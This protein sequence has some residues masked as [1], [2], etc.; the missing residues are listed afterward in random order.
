MYDNDDPVQRANLIKV[1]AAYGLDAWEFN[2]GGGIMH[3]VVTILDTSVEPPIISAQNPD[4]QGQLEEAVKTWSHEATLYIATNSLRTNCEIGLMGNDGR[5]GSQVA[6]AEW[7]HVDSLDEAVF[8]FRKFWN[9][10]D[11]W[12]QDFVEGKLIL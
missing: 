1:I 5:T 9:E 10:R 3:V 7:E 2:S 11:R 12:L 8:V 6:S 4:L